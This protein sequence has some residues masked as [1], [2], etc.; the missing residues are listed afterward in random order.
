M[1]DADDEDMYDEKGFFK[2]LFKKIPALIKKGKEIVNKV[3]NNPMVKKVME[4]EQF[5]K[6]KQIGASVLTGQQTLAEAQKGITQQANLKKVQTRV[7]HA[8]IM[9]NA[10]YSK[11]P[12]GTIDP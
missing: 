1:D 9:E 5:Q 3:K 8:P 12:T 7:S 2:S 11:Q 4:S 10:V 6:M